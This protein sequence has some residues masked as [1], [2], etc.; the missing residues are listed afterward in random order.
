MEHAERAPMPANS[1]PDPP[2][3]AQEYALSKMDDK[4]FK[5]PYG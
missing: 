1:T 2:L 5:N 3:R 4:E